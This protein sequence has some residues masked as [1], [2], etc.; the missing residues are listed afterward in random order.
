MRRAKFNP[1]NDNQN[2]NPD[3]GSKQKKPRLSSKLVRK[4]LLIMF[5]AVFV[6]IG[7]QKLKD[8]EEPE[9]ETNL[10]ILGKEEIYKILLK[11][12]VNVTDE[13]LERMPKIEDFTS[14][15]GSSPKIVGLETC[16]TFRNTVSPLDAIVGPAGVF[17]SGTNLV[18]TLLKKHCVI[19]E[20]ADAYDKSNFKNRKNDLVL[21][22]KTGMFDEMPWDKHGPVSWR[23]DEG[24]KPDQNGFEMNLV[25]PQLKNKDTFPIVMVKDPFSWMESMCRNPYTALWLPSHSSCL[26]LYPDYDMY[27]GDPDRN[28]FK[29]SSSLQN[30]MRFTAPQKKTRKKTIGLVIEFKN[31]DR[32]RRDLEY[33]NLIDWWNTFYDD[34]LKADFPRLI[35][36]YEDLLLHSNEIIPQICECVGG[37]LVNNEEGVYVRV[38]SAKDERIHGKTSNLVDALL[39]YG[40]AKMR[41]E[42]FSKGDLVYSGTAIRKD[43]MKV[44]QYTFPTLKDEEEE[45]KIQTPGE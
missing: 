16:E 19:Q 11:S 1:R 3:E 27:D 37:Q 17:N 8:D 18:S 12:G 9:M 20:R 2:D 10:N 39:R 29:R 13:L 31:G 35:V 25:L 45:F 7:C 42:K 22:V 43:M 4:W 40:S 38:E 21:G 41:T 24:Y 44:F 28:M 30:G 26:N 23:E 33:E 32:W 5:T 14:M 6:T 15:Y 34:Y 36:R